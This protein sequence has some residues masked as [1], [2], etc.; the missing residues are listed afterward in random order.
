[1]SDDED[2]T[3]TS[4]QQANA[5]NALEIIR[6]N[7]S[8]ALRE[9]NEAAAMAA[10]IDLVPG[11]KTDRDFNSVAPD[12]ITGLINVASLLAEDLAEERDVPIGQLLN[13]LADFLRRIE[14]S[15]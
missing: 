1:M 15:D 10:V 6:A 12:I 14:L 13:D 9:F 7:R 11:K 3:W 4:A 8:V 2:R 5:L